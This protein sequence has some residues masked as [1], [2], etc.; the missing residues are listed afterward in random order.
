M[1][2]I[3][4]GAGC[5]ITSTATVSTTG[6]IGCFTFRA[7]FFARARLGL[8]LATVRFAAFARAD[9][10]ALPRLAEFPLNSFPRFCTFARFLRFAMIAPLMLRNNTMLHSSSLSNA[11]YQQDRSFERAWA[12]A[13]LFLVAL[14]VGRKPPPVRQ[15]LLCRVHG[16]ARHV[17][18][19]SK[20]VGC[21]SPTALL[22]VEAHF[23]KKIGPPI[24][25]APSLQGAPPTARTVQC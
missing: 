16:V 22:F 19:E 1:T 15:T 4:P 3:T 7:V 5:S 17:G 11:S 2:A 8:A 21:V 6:A 10:R 14:G 18:D 12:G 25:A 20:A 23:T 24:A 9:L 13:L